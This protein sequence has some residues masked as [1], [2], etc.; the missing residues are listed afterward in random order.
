[1]ETKIVSHQDRGYRQKKGP[2]KDEEKTRPSE[3]EDKESAS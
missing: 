3:E 2:V 1:M